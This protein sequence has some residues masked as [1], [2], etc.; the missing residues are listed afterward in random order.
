MHASYSLFWFIILQFSI[1]ILTRHSKWTAKLGAIS[2]RGNSEPCYILRRISAWDD[3]DHIV[4]PRLGPHT[5]MRE[6][7]LKPY[8]Q[9]I[10]MLPFLMHNMAPSRW[11][12]LI[13]EKVEVFQSAKIHQSSILLG[14]VPVRQ[15][16]VLKV[17]KHKHN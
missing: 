17:T 15:S 16:L 12:R 4:F 1:R 6:S 13:A 8:N 7:A 3:T 5:D 2:R 10:S 14:M 11:K 9:T